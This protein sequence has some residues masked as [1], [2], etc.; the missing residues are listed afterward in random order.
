MHS[1]Y[2]NKCYTCDC[3]KWKELYP[4]HIWLTDDHCFIQEQQQLWYK[5]H[6]QNLQKLKQ[7]R[8]KLNQK[9]GDGLMLVPSPL[10]H[11]VPPPPPSD[12]PK[13]LPP[14]P[15][16]K[17]EPPVQPP[18]PGDVKVSVTVYLQS[19]KVEFQCHRFYPSSL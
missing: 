10:E 18:L 7:E 3:S 16:P 2:T 8:A 17:E 5:Q 15:P 14:P 4:G 1:C 6:L 13:G 9:E 11:T 12:P 19:L